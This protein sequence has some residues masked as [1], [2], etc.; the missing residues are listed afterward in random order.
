MYK[1]N[2]YVSLSDKDA[3]V[4][5]TALID[6]ARAE[7][8]LQEISKK[9][10][11][12]RREKAN[13]GYIDS[14]LWSISDGQKLED[15]LIRSFES[16]NKLNDLL[17]DQHKRTIA[18]DSMILKHE[19]GH[20]VHKDSQQN[21]SKMVAIPIAVEAVSF[22]ITKSSR[23][24]FNM[25]QQPKTFLKTTLRSSSA[26]GAIVPKAIVGLTS[27]IFLQRQQEAR[28]DRFACEHA[29]SRLELEE[30]AKFCEKLENS[31]WASESRMAV[32]FLEA[33]KDPIHP[34]PVDR[35]EKIESYLPKWD[36]EHPG[37]QKRS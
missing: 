8:N 36:R 22:G 26:V 5:S 29:A 9:L 34:A 32:R 23:K 6:Q 11:C 33:T 2:S 21:I 13:R 31:E 7:K 14:F 20:I 1:K 28:A 25:Q 15:Q 35:K 27:T 12:L 18:R 4:L 37:D 16:F 19:L 24:L 3:S 17:I 30:F 10:K